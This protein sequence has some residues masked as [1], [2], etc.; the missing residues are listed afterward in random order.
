MSTETFQTILAESDLFVFSGQDF[1]WFGK[2]PDGALLSGP[3]LPIEPPMAE[4]VNRSHLA[5]KSNN[6][7]IGGGTAVFITKDAVNPARAIEYM[8]FRY[9]DEAQIAE[10]FGIQGVTWEYDTDGKQIIWTK[11]YNDFLAEKDW[12]QMSLKYGPNNFQHSW[13]ITNA[14][15]KLESEKS[16][17]PVRALTAKITTPYQKNERIY[18]LTKV[19]KDDD[20]KMKYEQLLMLIGENQVRCITAKTDV[21]FENAF[22]SYISTANSMGLADLEKYYTQTYKKWLARGIAD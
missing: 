9:S 13:F 15:C 3:V 21:A 20:V 22:S 12:Y 10:R 18:D 6:S 5:L 8:A 4:G 2:V 7:S 11:E 14:I 16:D 17:Y 1:N 19:I